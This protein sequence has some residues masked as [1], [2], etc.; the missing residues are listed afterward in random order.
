MAIY[1]TMKLKVESTE[2][3]GTRATVTHPPT[4]THITGQGKT[5]TKFPTDTGAEK[6]IIA[7][8]M[9]PV[10]ISTHYGGTLTST[11]GMAATEIIKI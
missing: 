4:N 11:M 6:A 8:Q 5:T 10:Y 2:N 7:A 1:G 3:I 9:P